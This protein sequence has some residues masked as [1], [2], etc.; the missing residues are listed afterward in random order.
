MPGFPNIRTLVDQQNAGAGVYTGF[1]KRVT[2][3]TAAGF[4]QDLSMSSGNPKPQY[5]ASTPL[6]AATLAQS[7]DAGIYHGGA[8]SPKTLH[9]RRLLAMM[10]ASN[11]SVPLILLD[12]CLYYPFID[13]SI[14]DVQTMDN[15]QPL[16]RY[17]SGAGLMMLPVLVAPH[18]VGTGTFFSVSYTNAQGVAGQTTQS[19]QLCT[20]FVNG[21]VVTSP[22]AVGTLHAFAPFIP[23]APGDTG[24]QSIQSVTMTGALD[25]GLFTIALVRPLANLSILENT[26]AA[27]VDY[28]RDRA[29][30]A[31]LV[32]DDAYLNFIALANGSLANF[33]IFGE[34]E[35]V[36]SAH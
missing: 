10:V 26:A 14:P 12:Y 28:I 24:V 11:Q 21:T 3:T 4:W 13:E 29:L 30:S 7:T 18:A 33:D 8:V 31:A 1:R 5:Y 34:A 35:F 15:T 6:V 9:L 16:T 17:P 22:G 2:V 20:Q 36:E 25:V 23:L 27:E 32:V 19:C